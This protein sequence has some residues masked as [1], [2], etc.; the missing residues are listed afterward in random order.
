MA[1][2]Q[3]LLAAAQAQKSPFISLLEGAAQGFGQT[4]GPA[5]LERLKAMISMQ[6]EQE[7]RARAKEQNDVLMKRLAGNQEDAIKNN[8]NGVQAAR[9]P[10]TPG[11]RLEVSS[12]SPGKY[13]Y[14][15]GHYTV[16]KPKSLQS[17][18]LQGPDGKPMMANF[19]PESGKYYDTAGKVIDKPVPAPKEQ[20]I[21]PSLLYQM[22]K[23][24]EKK[25][26]DIQELQVPGYA[27]GKDV[28]PTQKE[29][30]D[31]RQASGSMRD[32]SIGVDR[33]V[34][35]INKHGSTKL[36][37]EVSGEMESL[38]ANLKLTLKEVQRLGV[39]S[40]SDIAFLDAQIF[41]PSRVRSL[42]TRTETA[43]KQLNTAKTRAESLLSQSLKARGYSPMTAAPAVEGTKTP[44]AAPGK[45]MKIGRFNV[46]VR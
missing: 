16:I 1:S 28:R 36:T 17:K 13:G 4:Q 45:T 8:L 29:A 6:Q 27:L 40:A 19:D 5:G 23:D 20:V 34:D 41:D 11:D 3:E 9:K 2:V 24:K 42:G 21:T 32:F 31:L 7:D 39:L 44:A 37:G 33:M 26:I 18:E 43:V 12:V 30:Q 35:L 14:A 10:N 22:E 38:A 46:T 25:Q 15:E